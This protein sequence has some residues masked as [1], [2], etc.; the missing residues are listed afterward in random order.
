MEKNV[1]PALVLMPTY[2]V[3]NFDKQLPSIF[4]K[5]TAL[6]SGIRCREEAMALEAPSVEKLQQVLTP[7]P[8]DAAIRYYLPVRNVEGVS[9]LCSFTLQ[10]EEEPQL[11]AVW[12]QCSKVVSSLSD[13]EVKMLRFAIYEDIENRQVCFQ[14][15]SLHPDDKWTQ[16]MLKFAHNIQPDAHEWVAS[17][18]SFESCDIIYNF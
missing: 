5:H 2:R 1:L 17:D 11:Y 10:F 16:L 18:I 8:K 4:K 12:C 14:S 6:I 15:Y 3:S 13:A 9:K 7:Y